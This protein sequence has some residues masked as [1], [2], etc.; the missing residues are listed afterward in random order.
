MLGLRPWV[1]GLVLLSIAG[2]AWGQGGDREEEPVRRRLEPHVD[3]NGILHM[4]HHDPVRITLKEAQDWHH[5]KWLLEQ[6][7]Q[8]SG[9]YVPMND[10]HVPEGSP[11]WENKVDEEQGTAASEPRGGDAGEE[12]KAQKKS[13]RALFDRIKDALRT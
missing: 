7:R 13:K 5:V 6:E 8:K 9:R 11:I 10:A 1:W 2:A 3:K 4:V 12:T